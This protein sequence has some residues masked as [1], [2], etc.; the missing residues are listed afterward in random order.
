M[1]ALGGPAVASQEV[2]GGYQPLH[3]RP[4]CSEMASCAYAGILGANGTNDLKA[5][6]A[7]VLCWS[8]KRNAGEHRKRGTSL[9][10][11]R[12]ALSKPSTRP[13]KLTKAYA[14]NV[15]RPSLT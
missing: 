10:G 1:K 14:R 2:Y 7:W 13:R 9:S 5:R 8:V 6:T 4:I 11:N 3:V 15:I 12:K